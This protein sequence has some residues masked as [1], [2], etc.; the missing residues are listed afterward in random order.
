M[1]RT[2][3]GDPVLTAREQTRV[4]TLRNRVARR[5][6]VTAEIVE[7]QALLEK[8]LDTTVQAPSGFKPATVLDFQ[9]TPNEVAAL[10]SWLDN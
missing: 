9:P 7:F 10:T 8:G 2:C 6:A 3:P 4:R 5:T 1:V